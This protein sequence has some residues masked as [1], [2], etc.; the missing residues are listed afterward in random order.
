MFGLRTLVPLLA[1]A[2]LL[3][4][5]AEATTTYYVGSSM[6]G[7]FNSAVFGM[8]LL[9]PALTFSG[10]P[11]STGLLNAD[12]TGIN[13][14][15]FDT[16]FSFNAPLSFTINSGALTATNAAEV[17]KVTF[18]SSGIYAFGLYVTMTSGSN[19]NWCFS[20][21]STAGACD[22]SVTNSTTSNVQFYGMLSDVPI[23]APLYITP[24]TGSPKV[25]FTQ[26]DAYGPA[27]TPEPRSMLLVGLGLITLALLR[28]NLI[29][30]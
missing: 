7:A 22:N 10:T 11:G 28:R 17:V 14:L 6:E 2:I 15:G 13:Y 19:V 5:P 27:T 21:A 30:G 3:V 26:F 9:D 24:Q 1:A 8:T 20:A 12:G 29:A 25:V 18:P 23:T 16:A 4:V